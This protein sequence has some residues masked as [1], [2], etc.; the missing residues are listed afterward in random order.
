MITFTSPGAKSLTATYVGDSNS[1]PVPPTKHTAI[2]PRPRPR[3][4]HHPSVVGQPVTV[5]YS[6]AVSAPGTGTPTGNVTV[7]D[8]TNSCTATVAAGQCALTFTSPGAKTLTATYAGDDNF[9]G[10]ASPGTTHTVNKADT[11][12]NITSDNP[13][14]SVVGEPITVAYSVTVIAP[15]AGTPTGT[16]T[17]SDGTISC[18]V[19]VATG[20]CTLTFTSPG[21]RTLTAAYTGDANVNGSTAPNEPHTVNKAATTTTIVSDNPDASAQGQVVTVVYSVAVS[22]PGAGTPTGNVT[23]GDGV[24]SCTATVA[25]GQCTVVFTTLGARTL[26]ATYTGD[27]NFFGN[28]SASEPHTV[29][30]P[31]ALVT[32]PKAVASYGDASV[33][34]TAGV[35][36]PFIGTLSGGTVTFTVR[37]GG[38]IRTILTSN[39]VNGSSPATVTVILPLNVTWDAGNYTVEARYD[40]DPC[41]LAGTGSGTLS[42]QRRM[43]WV[44]AVDRTVGLYQPNPSTTPPANCLAS[45]TATSV[46]WLQLANGSS[47]VYGQSWSA[48]NLANLRFTYSRNYPSSNASETVGKTYKISATGVFSTNYDIRYQQGTLTVVP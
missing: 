27:S 15:G 6:V 47:F 7:S 21:A 8:G 9:N 19:T 20:A 22:A 14:P 25:A 37:K 35:T 13:D 26:V 45:A 34:L 12:M 32:V 11:T 30:L 28:T 1:T 41:C 33:P 17:V 23:V 31:A 2:K 10:S 18:T 29:V 48:L 36:N 16:V 46:C 43:L 4:G 40:G 39:P 5:V 3:L 44:Q 42:I 38:T 24:D